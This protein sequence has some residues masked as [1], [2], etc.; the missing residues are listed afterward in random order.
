[1]S[2]EQMKA[3]SLDLFRK[4]FHCSQA[5]LAVG[6]ARLGIVNEEVSMKRKRQQ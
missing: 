1:M 6:Q 3:R 2:P 4:R 5:V